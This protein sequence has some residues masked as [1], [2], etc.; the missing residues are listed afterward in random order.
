[1]QHLHNKLGSHPASA[2]LALTAITLHYKAHVVFNAHATA[3]YCVSQ[4]ML[5]PISQ[6][7]SNS[8]ESSLVY[9]V[10]ISLC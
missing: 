5:S 8:C 1:M 3:V 4:N 9:Q 7:E 2:S 6:L 10:L